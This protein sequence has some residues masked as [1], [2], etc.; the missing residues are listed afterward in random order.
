[1]G[2]YAGPHRRPPCKP[3]DRV[4]KPAVF[5]FDPLPH[6]EPSPPLHV[7]ITLQALSL[8]TGWANFFPLPAA[9]VVGTP[10]TVLAVVG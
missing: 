9:R 6:T 10:G 7:T 5:S 8:V 3:R 1:M 4:K 2:T